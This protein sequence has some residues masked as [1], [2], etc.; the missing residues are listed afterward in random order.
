LGEPTIISANHFKIELERNF[1]ENIL[2]SGIHKDVSI[3]AIYNILSSII[4]AF[5]PGEIAIRIFS[6]LDNEE[7]S[8]LNFPL[9]D[10]ISSYFDYKFI[11]N[12]DFK[13]ELEAINQELIRRQSTN[14]IHSKRVFTFF[15][16]LEKARELFQEESYTNSVYGNVLKNILENG[17]AFNFHTICELRVPSVLNKLLYPNP[18][19][20][21]KHRIVF[22]LGNSEESNIV[23][24]NKMAGTLYKTDEP[25]TK[26]RGIYYNADFEGEY[27][28]FKPYI[29]LINDKMFY[30]EDFEI[31]FQFTKTVLEYYDTNEVLMDSSPVEIETSDNSNE[32]LKKLN[33]ELN[34]LTNL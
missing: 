29:D 28:K 14:N 24:Q 23:L 15:I 27:S 7:N 21:F 13:S 20:L 22:H 9:I 26:K 16:G 31:N 34:F 8:E 10:K 11:E 30:P 17:N 19:N 12:C 5:A 2:L 33:D 6:F 3:N 32:D 25:H 18:I 1:N 4:Y